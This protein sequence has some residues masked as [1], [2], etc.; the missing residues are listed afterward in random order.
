MEVVAVVFDLVLCGLR[1]YKIPM[2]LS[3]QF[4]PP[5]TKSIGLFMYSGLEWSGF[6]FKKSTFLFVIL[7]TFSRAKIRGFVPKF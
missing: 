2:A 7:A 6:Y 3:C 5:I 4:F 1:I